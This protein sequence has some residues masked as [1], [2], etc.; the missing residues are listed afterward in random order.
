MTCRTDK[1]F[2]PSLESLE[3]R[4]LP[5]TSITATLSGNIL[6]V[7][8]TD[9]ADQITVRQVNG[10]ISVDNQKITVNGAKVASVAAGAVADIY[11]YGLGGNDNLRID[12]SVTK[13]AFM[14]GGAGNDTLI[15]G[16]GRNIMYGQDGNDIIYG[17]GAD[18]LIYGGNGNDKLY[19]KGGND[20][21]Y[22]EAGDDFLQGN[23]G[24]DYLN[25]GAG[26]DTFRRNMTISGQAQAEDKLADAP[27]YGAA[28]SDDYRAID[29]ASAPTCAFLASLAATANWTG[30]FSSYGTINKDLLSR[31]SYDASKDQ[32]GVRLY[33][34][35]TWQTIWVTSDWN[36]DVDPR[37]PLWVTLY[38]KAYLKAMGVVNTFSDGTFLPSTMW[39]STTGKNWQFSANALQSLTG[40]TPTYRGISGLLPADLARNLS[41]GKKLV[42]DSKPNVASKFVANHSYTVLSV[43]QESGV[44]KLRLYNPWAHDGPGASTDGADD[45]LI[46]ITWSELQANFAGLAYN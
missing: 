16:T 17:S 44:W 25:G 24:S 12:G 41:A 36:E 37:G 27:N 40:Q 42:V 35:G 9:S 39:Q 11:V 20:M 46:T 31:I 38:Q 23:A 28:T 29:Q 3:T 33:V 2:Q 4:L 19:G 1:H 13:R 32:Y 14:Y 8:G 34:N 6:K 10:Q 30:R 15:G 5:A 43:F 26:S 21:L 7:E 18:D 45:G 22:G